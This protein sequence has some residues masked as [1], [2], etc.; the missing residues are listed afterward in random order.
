M[1]KTETVVSILALES[2]DTSSRSR[3]FVTWSSHVKSSPMYSAL[4]SY[5]SQQE[6]LLDVASN[7]PLGQPVPNMFFAAAHYLLLNGL[8]HPVKEIYPSLGGQWVAID[9]NFLLFKNYCLE[10]RESFIAAMQGRRVQTN[11]VARGTILL[12]ALHE[13]ANTF[14]NAPLTFIE[15][16][17]SAGLNLC[18]DKFGYLYSNGQTFHPER[19]P[20]LTCEVKNG[21]QLP[22][23]NLQISKRIGIDLNP[24]STKNKND[25]LWLKSLLWA[26]QVERFQR[27]SDA[28]NVADTVEMEL[29]KG[30]ATT[31][32]AEIALR[33]E[34]STI[35]CILNCYSLYMFPEDAKIAYEE[36]INKAGLQRDLAWLSFEWI[37][38]SKPEIYL[39][40]FKA[41]KK[42]T[43]LLAIASDHGAWIEWLK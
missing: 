9:K 35:P 41:G 10:N 23:S 4:S 7:A 2:D 12:P 15:V 30:D 34:P 22:L 18:C 43:K 21:S 3:K 25:I 17:T 28:V 31:L 16:G 38:S 1:Q 13:V 40:I 8:K 20:L 19:T 36:N 37:Y 26:D 32:A 42:E 27:F 24:I 14:G 29:V 33:A 11:E 6:E 5:V 39:N